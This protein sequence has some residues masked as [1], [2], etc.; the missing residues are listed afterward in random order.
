MQSMIFRFFFS[1][2]MR[3]F[4]L[5]VSALSDN[6]FKNNPEFILFSLTVGH[7]PATTL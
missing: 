1:Q 7:S 5:V 4:S 2:K 3:V 6:Y